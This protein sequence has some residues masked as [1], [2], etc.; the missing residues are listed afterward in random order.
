MSGAFDI[1]PGRAR[2]GL[3]VSLCGGGRDA[4]LH[5]RGG[6]EDDAVPELLI[7]SRPQ[8]RPQYF[9]PDSGSSG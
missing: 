2:S 5:A 8:G 3:P 6:R 4:R 7:R 1:A 9:S